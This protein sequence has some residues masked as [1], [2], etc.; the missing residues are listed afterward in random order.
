MQVGLLGYGYWGKILSSKLDQMDDV[1]VIW[2]CTSRD[3]WWTN[4]IDL[5]WVFIATPNGVHFEQVQHFIRQGINVFC[6]KPLTPSLDE[7]KYLFGL[8]LK[9]GVKLYVDDVFNYRNERKDIKNLTRPI[10]VTWNKVSDNILYDLLYHDLYLLFPFFKEHFYQSSLPI[11][12]PYI[13]DIKFNYGQSDD[14]IH[15]INDIDF[16]NTENSNDAL[17]DMI[18]KVLH[19]TPDYRYNKMTALMCNEIIDNIINN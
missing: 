16:T 14:R 7:S 18:N 4:V 8:A 5:D 6:E 10:E 15:K 11:N 12:W 19:G 9:H 13:N 3:Q 2:T 17:F 1:E